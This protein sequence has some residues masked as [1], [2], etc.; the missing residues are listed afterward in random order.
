[1]IFNDQSFCWN[2]NSALWTMP[3]ELKFSFILFVSIFFIRNYL[4]LF[5]YNI[6]IFT[7]IYYNEYLFSY[8]PF[9]LGIN[10]AFI[11]TKKTFEI[12]IIQSVCLIIV[13]N[14]MANNFHL[15]ININFIS[16]IIPVLGALLIILVALFSKNL[17]NILNQNI[18]IYLGKVSFSLYLIHNLILGTISSYVY[19]KLFNQFHFSYSLTY[20]ITFIVSLVFSIFA[21]GIT[22][23]LIDKQSLKLTNII[24]NLFERFILKKIELWTK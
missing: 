10:M 18:L 5:L 9:V 14:F 7:F 16:S 24:Y 4:T 19:L 6:I 22:Y 2:I 23:E 8:A 15:D 20:A 13:A 3:L 21:A 11:F 1:M 12:N 17:Q